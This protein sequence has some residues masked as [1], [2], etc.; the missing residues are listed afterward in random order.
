MPPERVRGAFLVAPADVERPGLVPGL[1]LP[2]APIPRDPLPFPSILVASR[3]DP[4]CAYD[5][6]EDFAYAWGRGGRGCGR[7]R[8]SQYRERTRALAG[9][10]DALRRLLR[11]L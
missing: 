7:G 11:R 3:A 6:A 10:A 2:F 1:D 9:R 4:Y 5:R 8:T